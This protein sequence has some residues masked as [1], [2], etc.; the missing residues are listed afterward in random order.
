MGIF[1]RLRNFIQRSE[2]WYL[3]T[4]DRALDEAYD[5][6][7]AIRAIEEQHF[8]GQKIEVRAGGYSASSVAYFETE[9]RKNLKLMRVRLTEFRTSRTTIDITNPTASLYQNLELD[10]SSYTSVNGRYVPPAADRMAITLEKLKY[11]DDVRLRYEPQRVRPPKT[12]LVPL[13]PPPSNEL[14]KPRLP[15]QSDLPMRDLVE[16]QAQI[17]AQAPGKKTSDLE[18]ITDKTGV[19]PRSILS[20]IGRLKRD[21]DPSSAEEAAQTQ[22][23]NYAKTFIS[24]RFLLLLISLTLLAQLSTRYLLLSDQLTPGRLISAQFGPAQSG[25]LFINEELEERAF[26]DMTRYEERLRFRNLL[27]ESLGKET[28]S[29]EMVEEQVK[30]HVSELAVNF[31]TQSSDA[32][33]NW[34]A[35]LMGLI[36]FCVILLNS[37]REIEILK[38]FIDELVYGLSDSAKA[39]II[40]LLTDIFVGFHSPHGWEVLLEAVSNH[41]GLPASRNFIFLFIATFPVILD[42]IFKY[43]IFR[44]LNRVSPSAVATY[45]EMNE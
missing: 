38:S 43:W 35:D 4:P 10:E 14:A 26:Q 7:L 16:R 22:R 25:K 23:L 28:L 36:V 15:R 45:K 29:K 20:T 5:A 19:L 33:K 31:S 8:K 30:R 44:Y 42:T 18:S 6:A 12:A 34:I 21:L 9:L 1:S 13:D 17:A 39:F 27:N 2:R 41:L 32:V 40:I 3:T 37:R 24:V 11:I